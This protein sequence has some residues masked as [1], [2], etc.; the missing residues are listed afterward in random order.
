MVVNSFVSEFS[1]ILINLKVE[2][3]ILFFN[4]TNKEAAIKIVQFSH[5][6]KDF[7]SKG[8]NKEVIKTIVF[9]V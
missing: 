9:S 4:A 5:V 1:P 3:N 2:C 6:S 8:K 7:G